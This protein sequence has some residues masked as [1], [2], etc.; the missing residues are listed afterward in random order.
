VTDEQKVTDEQIWLL[1]YG[2]GWVSWYELLDG[3]IGEQEVDSLHT[4]LLEAG[5]IQID[6]NKLRVRLKEK[7]NEPIRV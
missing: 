2:R 3:P 7:T 4:R 6:K 5:K 1:K